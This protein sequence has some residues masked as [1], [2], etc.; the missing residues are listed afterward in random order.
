MKNKI[1]AISLDQF[2]GIQ[3]KNKL[4]EDLLRVTRSQLTYRE[5]IERLFTG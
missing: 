5:H 3:I 1:K 4:R 2:V